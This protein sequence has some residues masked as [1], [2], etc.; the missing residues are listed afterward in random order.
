[1]GPKFVRTRTAAKMLGKKVRTVRQ[2]IWDNKLD[3]V[4]DANGRTWLVFLDEVER[5][6]AEGQHADKN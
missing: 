3:A 6:I 4:K 5:I 1:M 2:W